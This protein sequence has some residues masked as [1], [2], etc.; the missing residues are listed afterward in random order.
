M[1]GG[2]IGVESVLSEGSCFRVR[3]PIV[4]ED[5]DE[6]AA[7]GLE[8]SEM[9]SSLDREVI[10]DEIDQLS[11]GDLEFDS[12]FKESTIFIVEDNDELRAM[13]MEFVGKHYQ[14]E[15]FP[16]GAQAL[17]AMEQVCPT[18]ILSDVAMPEMDG[19]ELCRAVKSTIAMSH[20]PII[21]ITACTSIDEKIK[22]RQAGA[23]IY[24]SKPFYPKYV[25]ACVEATLR[26][27]KAIRAKFKIGIPVE[28]ANEIDSEKSNEFL[29]Q[30]YEFLDENLSNEDIDLKHIARKMYLNRTY[31]YQKV[32]AVTNMTPYEFI[33][34]Y[35]LVKA[36]EMLCQGEK[37]ISEICFDTGFKNR[38][39]FSRIF[40][41]RFG[42][43]PSHYRKS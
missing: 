23:D 27:H 14:V 36:A 13:M 33:K 12:E 41:E 43:T 34:E 8:S 20:I 16:N 3:L 2:E 21:L 25:L 6:L 35:R 30:L 22:C 37:P 31:F 4:V 17:A 32:K 42:V 9:G 19:Y 24:I 10:T 40:K 15:G 7:S 26:N 38:T 5:Y 29:A 28:S 39:H 1:H 18:L 11:T